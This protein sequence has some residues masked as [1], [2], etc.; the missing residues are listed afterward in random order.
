MK[1]MFCLAVT[2]YL[3]SILFAQNPSDFQAITK[4]F[5][6][7]PRVFLATPLEGTIF[8]D[9]QTLELKAI[10]YDP[11]QGLNRVEFWVDDV[12]VGEDRSIPF[13]FSWQPENYG[14]YHVKAVAYDTE[15]NVSESNTHTLRIVNPCLPELVQAPT[16]STQLDRPISYDTYPFNSL[17]LD[18]RI[19]PNPVR[20]G[21][22]RLEL[23]T[24]HKRELA[25]I[26]IINSDGRL[27]RLKELVLIE[28]NTTT[29]D[30]RELP[31]GTYY[32]VVVLR[33]D[34]HSEQFVLINE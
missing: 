30:V 4:N 24:P 34:V 9:L 11:D 23:H 29:I 20:G 10:A 15:G 17:E 1:T 28:T 32:A 14:I 7:L 2:I 22:I 26:R 33:D 5:K 13:R 21:M 31:S 18:I 8:T 3:T 25:R 6:Q 27:V 12:M 16:D 19:S